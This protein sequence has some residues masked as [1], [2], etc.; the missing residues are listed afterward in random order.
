[1]API[2]PSCQDPSTTLSLAFATANS[3]Q[4]DRAVEAEE[5]PQN[6]TS[7]TLSSRG[8]L[9]RSALPK[10]C[11]IRETKWKPLPG[12]MAQLSHYLHEGNRNRCDPIGSAIPK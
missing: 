7:Q 6:K 9:S 4:D 10:C 5:Q 12:K 8:T 11:S 1:M 2:V 3:A